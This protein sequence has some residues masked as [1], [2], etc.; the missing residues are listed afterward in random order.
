MIFIYISVLL[1]NITMLLNV[2]GSLS[3]FARRFPLSALIAG[4]LVLFSA[5]RCITALWLGLPAEEYEFGDASRALLDRAA[6]LIGMQ[7]D[8]KLK[9]LK[10]AFRRRD[11]L[12]TSRAEATMENLLSSFFEQTAVVAA[13]CLKRDELDSERLS[14]GDV[15]LRRGLAAAVLALL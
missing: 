10:T 1:I 2:F 6:A 8:L 14:W 4:Y 7:S 11:A 13:R 15:E 3:G 5:G 9:K 12:S